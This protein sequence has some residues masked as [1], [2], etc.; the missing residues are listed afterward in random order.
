MRQTGSKVMC[1]DIRRDHIQKHLIRANG[2]LLNT[3][4]K[5]AGRIE[6]VY[7]PVGS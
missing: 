6:R 1:N 5:Q 3:A 7:Y 2:L 4:R